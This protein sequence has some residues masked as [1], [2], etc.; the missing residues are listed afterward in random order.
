MQA[1]DMERAVVFT[2]NFADLTGNAATQITATTNSSGV[3]FDKTAPTGTVSYSTTAATKENVTATISIAGD[4]VITNNGGQATCEFTSNGTF[5]F[6]L[7]DGAGNTAQVTAT[8]STIDKTAPTAP[9]VKISSNNADTTKAKVGDTITLTIA[10]S[11]DVGTPTVTIAGKSATVANGG[12]SDAKTWIASYTMQAGDTEGAIAFTLNVADLVG[13]AANQVTATTNGSS[14][15]FDKTA[16]TAPTISAI[17]EVK[18]NQNVMVSI[19]YPN[20]AAVKQYKQGDGNW[21]AYVS[22]F[23]VTVNTMVYAKSTDASGNDSDVSSYAVQNIDKAE[24]VI[25][26]NGEDEMNL[27]V[28]TPYND[29]G[30]TAQD[31]NDGNLTNQITVTGS[32]YAGQLGSYVLRYNVSDSSGNQAEEKKRTVY[33]V[34]TTKPVVTLNG[35]QT[36]LVPVGSTFADPGATAT[37]NY[38]GDI[39]AYIT[40]TGSVY[41]Q[42]L[43]HYPI[44]YLVTDSSGNEGTVTRTVTVYDHEHPVIVLQGEA[45]V[46][47]E[48]G[49]LFQEPGFAAWDSQDGDLTNAVTVTGAVYHNQLGTYTLEYN[50]QDLSGN[51]AVKVSRTIKVV[52]TIKPVIT[53]LGG[54]PQ[55]ISQGSVYSDPGVTATDNYDGDL[56]E[57]VVVRGVVNTNLAGMYNLIYEVS[58]SSRNVAETERT[59]HVRSNDATLK[60]LTVNVGILSPVFAPAVY[61]YNAYVENSVSQITVTL[62][63]NE[64]HAEV[65]VNNQ[66]HTLDSSGVAEAV[67]TLTVGQN[68]ML[69]EVTAHDGSSK[70]YTLHVNRQSSDDSS[71]SPA[72]PTSPT[73]PSNNTGVDVLVNGKVESAGTAT[74]GEVN[75]QRVTSIQIDEEKLQLRLNEEGNQAVITIPVATRSD[76]VVG[77]LNGRMVKNMETKQAVVEIRTENATYTLPAQQINI[78]AVSER[79]GTSLELQ[80]IKVRIEIA[81]PTMETVQVVENAASTNGLTIMIPPLN[82]HVK[83]VYGDRTE[84]VTKFNAYVERMIAIPKGID[85]NRIT[86]GIVVDPDGTVRHVPTKIVNIDGVYYAQINSLS[87]STY[88]VVW[89]PLEFKDVTSHWAKDAVNNMGSRMVINGTGGELFS[90]DRDITRAEFAAI[91]VRGLGLLEKGV[92]AFLDVKVP[93]WYGSAVQTAYEYGLINGFEDGTFRPNEKITREQAM[94]IVSKAMAITRL[95]SANPDRASDDILIGFTDATKVSIWAKSGVADSVQAGIISGRDNGVLEPK[96]F[97]TRAEVAMMM[98][99]LLQKSNLI[100]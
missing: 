47:L 43:G 38:N 60:Q 14:V 54:N 68:T 91:I 2:L 5:T 55:L 81:T 56:S 69:I 24:P 59:V 87:N 76:V 71:N 50:V 13:N 33:V 67:M 34:D 86:T 20:D 74:T 52:D 1:G 82:F 37:D 83:V 30:A 10:T 25:T 98:Q 70:A 93:D 40:V 44:T 39:T 78:D 19:S 79:F 62:Q 8:V 26:L 22:A 63:V 11:E 35:N 57:Q 94:V 84:E 32:V 6:E 64:L 49:R 27:E 51:E 90:P 16:P 88:S 31:D 72:Q 4:T 23:E 45:N 65:E 89:H 42:I 9:T 7:K 75:G 97:I 48:V 80:D 29:T 95:Q 21:Q 28:G 41:T 61:T 100:N 46:I 15:T 53:L 12:D 18:T 73:T 36:I 17:P 77:E 96:A 3:T 99:R 92:S 58:D 85:P 66:L